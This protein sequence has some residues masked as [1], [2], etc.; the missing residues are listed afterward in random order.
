MKLTRA[1]HDAP[2]ILERFVQGKERYVAF[3]QASLLKYLKEDKIVYHGLAGHFFVTG[4][5]HVLKVR[6]IADMEEPHP[7]CN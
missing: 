2:S 1:V 3:I 6:I 5:S 4:V 7:V